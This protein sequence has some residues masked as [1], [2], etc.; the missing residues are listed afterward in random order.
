M[1]L[2]RIPEKLF[3]VSTS[4][5]FTIF[6]KPEHS[7]SEL[8]TKLSRITDLSDISHLEELVQEFNNSF[9]PCRIEYSLENTTIA[10]GESNTTGHRQAEA[11]G[12]LA[13]E[14]NMSEKF[15]A[16]CIAVDETNDQEH[17]YVFQEQLIKAFSERWAIDHEQTHVEKMHELGFFDAL[18]SQDLERMVAIMSDVQKPMWLAFWNR[19]NELMGNEMDHATI[20]KLV[21]Q[22]TEAGKNSVKESLEVFLSTN[23]IA[24]RV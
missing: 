20:I 3:Q 12:K 6:S 9:T 17:F 13:D 18:E 2:L 7:N 4:A 5:T 15:D 21:E 14:F 23:T 16:A 24:V 22:M 10:P 11:M 1:G 19:I 8:E